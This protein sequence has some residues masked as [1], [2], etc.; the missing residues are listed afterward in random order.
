MAVRGA[1]WVAIAS[2]GLV[3][4]LAMTHATDTAD[5]GLRGQLFFAHLGGQVLLALLFGVSGLM[6]LLGG[7]GTSMVASQLAQIWAGERQVLLIDLDVQRGNAALY[8]NLKPRLSIADLVEAEDRLD[9]HEHVPE[10]GA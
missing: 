8:L 1:A 6:T 9:A 10:P 5:T 4:W 2:A 7:M 3:G